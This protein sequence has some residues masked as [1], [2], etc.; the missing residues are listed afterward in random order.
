MTARVN[1]CRESHDSPSGCWT[2]WTEGL[3]IV[4]QC[5]REHCRWHH[6]LHTQPSNARVEVS[7]E[8][9]HTTKYIVTESDRPSPLRCHV[10]VWR[11]TFLTHSWRP[12]RKLW[13]EM[14]RL[15]R[16]HDADRAW[17]PSF[18]GH[19]PPVNVGVQVLRCLRDSLPAP[20]SRH[21]GP[22]LGLIRPH[23]DIATVAHVVVVST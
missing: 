20:G 14:K 22:E 1:W 4:W 23:T 15:A 6:D 5:P 12:S 10:F 9:H 2:R 7:R 19:N 17:L 13:L 3:A 8:R 18:G 11:R 16:A 21:R